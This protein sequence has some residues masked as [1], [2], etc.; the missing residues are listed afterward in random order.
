MVAETLRGSQIPQKK[1]TTKVIC[2]NPQSGKWVAAGGLISYEPPESPQAD[3]FGIPEF[4][5][6][7]ESAKSPQA[8]TVG[9]IQFSFKVAD[10][11]KS[12]QLDEQYKIHVDLGRYW[13][14]PFKKKTNKEIITISNGR[15]SHNFG[16]YDLIADA[17]GALLSI[18][19]EF[20]STKTAFGT[21]KYR[22][23]IPKENATTGI[24]I[25][26]TQD[27]NW[28]AEYTEKSD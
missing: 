12:I 11:Q 25:D 6:K 23:K 24:T 17:E 27:G 7:S 15:F 8:R 26:T 4:F 9:G 28:Y 16:D 3:R 21:Y 13:A 19:G 18:E 22:F 5:P 2:T 10:D 14:P 1:S 20:A